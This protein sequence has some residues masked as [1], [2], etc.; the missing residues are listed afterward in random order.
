MPQQFTY[1]NLSDRPRGR[2]LSVAGRLLPGIDR[3]QG[4]VVPFAQ[5]WQRNNTAAAELDG[6]LWVVLGDSLCQGIG[7][8]EP[9]RGWVGLANRRLAVEGHE[10]R[11]LNL[12]VSGA[13]TVDLI[14]RQ[15][16]VLAALDPALVTVMIGSNDLRRPS[17]RRGLPERFEQILH[18][19]PAGSVV[20]TLPNPSTIA[21][22]V[23]RRIESTAAA[24]D[25]VVVQMRDPRTASWRGRL[26]ED[27]FHPNDAGYAAIAAV[28]GDALSAVAAGTD[29]RPPEVDRWRQHGSQQN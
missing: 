8:S 17:L 16:P 5:A 14:E 26:A 6:P 21:R 13:T 20:T 4:D 24:R 23:N 29:S 22:R 28:V 18:R 3:V 10:F 25:L 9:M 11:L 12:A 1:S 15:L 2:L 19:V 27:R 7:A